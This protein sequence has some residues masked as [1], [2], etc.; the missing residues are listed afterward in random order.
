MRI[1]I[2]SDGVLAQN[3]IKNKLPHE[4]PDAEIREAGTEAEWLDLLKEESFDLAII[5]NHREDNRLANTLEMVQQ[6]FP[7]LPVLTIGTNPQPAFLHH[8]LSADSAGYL[9][10]ETATKELSKA[11]RIVLQGRH[12]L[13]PCL[14]KRLAEEQEAIYNRLP[15][16][17]LSAREYDVFKLLASGKSVSEIA[18][19]NL[20]GVTTVSTY[21]SRLLAKMGFRTNAEIIAYAKRH[22]LV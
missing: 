7:H 12:Y 20:L 22:Q 9:D 6:N 2:I 21:R 10:E 4:F 17:E 13:T 5:N 3:D 19:S 8:L 1:I 18:H 14:E 16:E 11:V 15:H